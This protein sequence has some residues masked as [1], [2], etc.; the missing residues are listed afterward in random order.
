M[1]K[2]EYMD[3]MQTFQ[4]N[5]FA[6]F[7]T[8]MNLTEED[9]ATDQLEKEVVFSIGKMTLVHYKPLV[10]ASKIY[11]TPLMITYALINR[12][13]ML[14]LQSDRSVVKSLLEAGNDVYMIDWG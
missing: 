6:G 5:L 14:N 8:L 10:K 9:V 1:M 7:Q 3:E 11:K 4:K 12:Q 13:N 2:M